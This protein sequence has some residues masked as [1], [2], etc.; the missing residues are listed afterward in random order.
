MAALDEQVALATEAIPGIA[1]LSVF[2]SRATGTARP[3]SDLDVA[4]LP[5]GGASRR[6]LQVAVAVALADLAP[7][8][9]VDVILLDEAP[10]LLRHQV[11][12]TGRLVLCRDARAWRDLRVQTMREHGDREW[13]RDL[14]R[15]ATAEA[16]ERGERWSIGTRCPVAWT[17]SKPTWLSCGPSDRQPRRVR[18]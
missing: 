16:R 9:R 8:G 2:G 5:A 17:H 10:E 15:R 3:D 13:V 14:L 1:A 18:A 6:H 11:L 7:E 4:V 12:A